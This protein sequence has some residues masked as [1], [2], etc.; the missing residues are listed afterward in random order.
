MPFELIPP[1][2]NIDFIGKRYLCAGISV[3]LLLAGLLAIPL[4]G[5]RLGIDFA[6]GTEVQIRFT[7]GAEIDAGAI[8]KVVDEC[9][10]VDASVVR[11]GELGSRDYLIRFRAG[12]AGDETAATQGCPLNAEDAQ[13]LAAAQA[14]LG[15]SDDG[16]NLQVQ[17][18]GFAL[19]N[20]VGPLQV[21]RVEFVGARVGSDLRRA[22]FYSLGIASLL[23]LIYI[24]F[25]FS[26]GF[27]PGA[28]VALFHDML[29]VAGIFVVMGW[30]FDLTV[31]AALL[32]IMGYSLN[33]TIVIYDRIRENL[34]LHTKYDLIDVLNRSVNQTLSRTILTG[35]TTF[36]SCIGLMIL[37][38]P[39]VRPFAYAMAIGIVVGTFSS[40][41]VA[42]PILLYLERR[43]GTA[44]A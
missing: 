23:I 26:A 38:G 8:R 24:G 42:A 20:A 39:V 29:I 22:A 10:I 5:V 40:I 19:T 3:A 44:R 17:R 43:Q 30:Q 36:F 9:G 1:G 35:G 14:A 15:D 6:G 37:G 11:F 27:A 28:V 21:E 34:S 32:T 33:D 4:R 31:L 13:K 16:S 2:T 7:E 18:L 41:Y 25:R 12:A